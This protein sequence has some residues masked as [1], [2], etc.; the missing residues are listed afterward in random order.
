VAPKIEDPLSIAEILCPEYKDSFECRACLS[1]VNGSDAASTE[2]SNR[3]DT[4]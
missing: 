1:I 4:E 3:L 2:S